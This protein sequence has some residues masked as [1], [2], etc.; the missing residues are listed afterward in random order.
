[1]FMDRSFIYGQVGRV[2][3]MMKLLTSK[4]M[5]VCVCVCISILMYSLK[6]EAM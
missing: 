2:I 6:S 4:G 1:M 5:C 3:S